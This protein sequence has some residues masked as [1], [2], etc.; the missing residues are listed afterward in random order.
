MTLPRRRSQIAAG[1]AGALPSFPPPVERAGTLP[2]DARPPIRVICF[3]KNFCACDDSELFGISAQGPNCVATLASSLLRAG[4]D[5]SCSLVLYRGGVCIGKTS[6]G[7]A[8]G[9]DGHE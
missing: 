5:P 2:D 8:A 9:A 6:I 1:K 7:D 4:R 3:G